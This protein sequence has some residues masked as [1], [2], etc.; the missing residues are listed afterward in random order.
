MRRCLSLVSL[1]RL[2]T[3]GATPT[4]FLEQQE[5]FYLVT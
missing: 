5:T 3:E 2:L 4:E 1:G